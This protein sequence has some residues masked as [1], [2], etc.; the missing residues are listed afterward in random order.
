VVVGSNLFAPTK[1]PRANVRP[2]R[3]R[4]HGDLRRLPTKLSARLVSP[5]NQAFGQCQADAILGILS[6][7]DAPAFKAG[8]AASNNS[9]T[10]YFQ[11]LSVHKI[12]A[13]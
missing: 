3:A 9:G 5:L 10:L 4:N 11:Q 8:G 6:E 12:L 7:K 13:Q 1:L 2:R